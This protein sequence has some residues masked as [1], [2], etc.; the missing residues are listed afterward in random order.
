MV[1]PAGPSL[2][3]DTSGAVWVAE[4]LRSAVRQALGLVVS[5]GVAPNKLLAKLGSRAAK[6]DGVHVLGSVE[7]VQVL[8]AAAPVDRLPGGVMGCTLLGKFP[9]Y[10]KLSLVGWIALGAAI[11]LIC[12][13]LRG[14]DVCCR[15][16]CCTFPCYSNGG[17]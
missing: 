9:P 3:W 10:A 15:L 13:G 6:P 11:P 4:A 8:L 16:Q 2:S 17:L 1:Y 12:R 7:A 5:V 14:R